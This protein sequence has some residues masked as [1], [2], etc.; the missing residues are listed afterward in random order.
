MNNKIMP[1]LFSLNG[2]AHFRGEKKKEAYFF[3]WDRVPHFVDISGQ[4]KKEEEKRKRKKEEEDRKGSYDFLKH[5]RLLL[6]SM[7]RYICSPGFFRIVIFIV[8]CNLIA[9]CTKNTL[10]SLIHFSQTSFY[11]IGGAGQNKYLC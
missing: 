9:F 11:R 3:S 10:Y 8:L 5:I 4:I 7:L 6:F 2:F 1:A